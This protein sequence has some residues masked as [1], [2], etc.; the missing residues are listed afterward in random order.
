MKTGRISLLYQSRKRLNTFGVGSHA[1]SRK[2]W[3]H[4]CW[5]WPCRNGSRISHLHVLVKVRY[6]FTTISIHWD[7][8]LQPSYRWYGKGHLV[9]EVDAQ[10]FN[11]AS[12][13]LLCR[14]SIQ[15]IG[16]HQRPPGGS[17]NS[18]LKQ[19]TVHST[20][21]CFVMSLKTRQPNLV[22]QPVDDPIVEQDRVGLV[23]SPKWA[24][25]K[26]DARVPDGRG[27]SSAVRSILAWKA[28]WWSCW[29]STIDRRLD[30][31]I[32]DLPF[33]VGRLKTGTLSSYRCARA[34]FFWT[35]GSARW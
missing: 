20:K 33:R 2:I 29:R 13:Y 18:R 34:D 7:N 28:F 30:R 4:R 3:R 19:I 14:Y 6:Y 32:R 17:C 16:T 23:A 24:L 35:W 12:Y 15:N 9:K 27:H 31:R 1:L 22:Q 26:A 10:V 25:G 21:P 5:W 8:V 11:G